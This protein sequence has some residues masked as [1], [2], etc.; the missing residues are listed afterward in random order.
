MALDKPGLGL[1]RESVPELMPVSF[2]IL[3]DCMQSTM[4]VAVIMNYRYS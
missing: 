1:F 4:P 2:R 3:H